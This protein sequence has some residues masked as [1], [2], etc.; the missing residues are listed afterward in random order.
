M[1][2]TEIED[3]TEGTVAGK[4]VF[5]EIMRATKAHLDE[6]FQKNRIRGPEYSQVYLGSIQHAMQQSVQF[7][8]EKDKSYYQAQLVMAQIKL[9]EQQAENAIIE[10]KNLEL[11][12]EVLSQQGLNLAAERE[13]MLSQKAL[14]EQQIVNLK[15]EELNIPKQGQKLDADTALAV[16]NELNAVIEGTVLTAQ[17]CKLTAEF[18]LIMEQK[19]KTLEETGLLAQKKATEKAQTV[20]QGVDDDSVIGRQKG[21]YKSQ[22]DGY[23]RD[24]EQKA[25][26]VL[27]D[28][29]NVRRTT[30][31]GTQANTTNRLDDANVGR[32]IDK[33][34]GGVGA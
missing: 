17:E 8:L 18:D 9:A 6:E 11:Q 1:A 27:A 7:L 24:A 20:G 25:A 10:G 32:V 31:E 3:L 22:S 16:Q 13:N 12:G 14:V 21:L 5:D 34:L 28:T 4:G 23:A 2:L 19:L 26:K 33:L 30:D 15:A 29:W